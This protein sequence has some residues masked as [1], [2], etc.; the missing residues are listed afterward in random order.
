[1]DVSG[2]EESDGERRS[3]RTRERERAR[4]I[5]GRE[6]DVAGDRVIQITVAERRGQP[7][8][9]GISLFASPLLALFLSCPHPLGTTAVDASR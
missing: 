4:E 2:R 8:A 9:A 7:I 3:A 5:R 1:M 6:R